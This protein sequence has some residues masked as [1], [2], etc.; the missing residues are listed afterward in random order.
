MTS[1]YRA[2]VY[3][4]GTSLL[5]KVKAFCAPLCVF[6]RRKLC[7]QRDAE[8]AFTGNTIGVLTKGPENVDLKAHDSIKEMFQSASRKLSQFTKL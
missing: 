8:F 3:F 7:T 6:A 5:R 4:G 1:L 2:R